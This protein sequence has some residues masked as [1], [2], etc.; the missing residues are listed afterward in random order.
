[1]SQ[2]LH[3][4]FYVRSVTIAHMKNITT[5][6]DEKKPPAQ[7]AEAISQDTDAKVNVDIEK[8]N[9]EITELSEKNNELVVSRIT[10]YHK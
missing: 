3:F 6:T 8:L 10:F 1:M 5:V 9:K 4:T 7:E 2:S